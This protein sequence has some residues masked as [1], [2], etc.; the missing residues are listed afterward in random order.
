MSKFKK[1]LP[2]LVAVILIAALGVGSAVYLNKKNDI[3]TD[4]TSV[5]TEQTN[6]VGGEQ[7]E[8]TA[9]TENQG[10]EMTQT[11]AQGEA[12]QVQ[13]TW[14][15]ETAYTGGQEV[16][17]N[18]KR[19]RAKWWTQG[20]VPDA[21]GA[22]GPW[23]CVGDA[24]PS[25]TQPPADVTEA[26]VGEPVVGSTGF[27]VVGYYPSW[28]PDKLDRIQYDVLTHINYAFAIPTSDGG[29]REL[30]SP[31]TAK[32]IIEKAHKHNV[33][34]LIAV[35]GWSYKDTP[36]EPTFK[37]ATNSDEKIQKFASAI[38]NM[39]NTYG[40]DGVDMD[41]EHPRYGDVTATQYTKLMQTLSQQLKSKGKL[42]TSAVLSGVSVDGVVYYDAAAHSDAVISCVDWFNVMAYDGGDGDRHSPY[43]FAVNCATY[44]RDTRKM[45]KEKVV[46]GVPFYARP[47][48]AP[49]SDLL[50]ADSSADG[51]DMIDYNGMQAH[52]NGV[53]TIKKKTAWALDNI[54]GVM[55][56]EVSQD[57]T[58]RSKSLLSAIADAIREHK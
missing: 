38:M 32:K 7:S 27:K 48:W 40:F 45:P 12:V 14:T 57:T 26:P 15:K 54:G 39:V 21:A 9:A 22:D 2:F 33:K 44:W 6:A 35:G 13:D 50:Q 1:I 58:D 4:S 5:Q 16:I 8:A 17:Y 11:T 29:L 36:L 28:E 10:E 25:V 41:W 31:E 24:A 18:G 34:V 55:M 30:E 19:Y 51:K 46:L 3:S 49:Y 42:L 52:Y 53:A 23:E 20:D 37:E 43:D 47:S 56:W